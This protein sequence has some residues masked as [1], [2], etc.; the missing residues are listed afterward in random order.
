MISPDDDVDRYDSSDNG[1]LDPVSQRER[2]HHDNG[3]DEGQTVG[4]LSQEN[5]EHGYLLDI[6]EAVETVGSETSCGFV[7]S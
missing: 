6:L 3:E 1:T 2:E 4:D 7:A 5:L